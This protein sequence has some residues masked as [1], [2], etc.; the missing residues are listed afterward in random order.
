MEVAEPIRDALRDYRTDFPASGPAGQLGKPA[1]HPLHRQ[2][3]LSH[4]LVISAFDSEPTFD[5]S[6]NKLLM[7]SLSV[8]LHNSGSTLAAFAP[9]GVPRRGLYTGIM[10]VKPT[11]GNYGDLEIAFRSHVDV[12]AIKVSNTGDMLAIAEARLELDEE[13]DSVLAA[14]RKSTRISACYSYRL[15]VG[16]APSPEG[17]PSRSLPPL[18]IGNVA[19]TTLRHV[20]LD[21][22]HPSISPDLDP[23]EPDPS[24]APLWLISR[25]WRPGPP[26]LTEL[27]DHLNAEWTSWKRRQD[28]GR[29]TGLIGALMDDSPGGPAIV[30]TADIHSTAVALFSWSAY[31]ARGSRWSPHAESKPNSNKPSSSLDAL[32]PRLASGATVPP[33]SFLWHLAH[34]LLDCA[35][36]STSL[37]YRHTSVSSFLKAVWAEVLVALEQ[38]LEQGAA[39]PGVNWSG[40]SDSDP[41]PSIDLRRALLHQK[42]SMLNCCIRERNKRVGQLDARRASTVLVPAPDPSSPTPGGWRRERS[43]S[44]ESGSEPEEK[45]TVWRSGLGLRERGKKLLGF[46]RREETGSGAWG[47]LLSTVEK[48]TKKEKGEANDGWSGDEAEGDVFY[49]A[50]AEGQDMPASPEFSGSEDVAQQADYGT[51]F[52]SDSFIEVDRSAPKRSSLIVDEDAEHVEGELLDDDERSGASELWRDAGGN[53]IKLLAGGS[54]YIPEVQEHGHMTED[55]VQSLE[56]RLQ[57]LGHGHEAA[58]AR[59]EMQTAQLRSDMEAF[60]AANPHAVLEDFVRWHSPRDCTEI[61]DD[62]GDVVGIQLSSRMLEPGNLWQSLWR[63]A[64]RIPAVSQTPLFDFEGE[65]KKVMS[66]LWN[67][68][69]FDI[70]NQ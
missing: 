14:A 67:L 68:T 2:T 6:T 46:E 11:G 35:S 7:S 20:Q 4:F 37:T 41:G 40:S 48:N 65:A 15:S 5:L 38:C 61:T 49:E 54:F 62:S 19:G 33:D 55:M 9:I 26:Q 1:P 29:R 28:S 57:N 22:Y 69:P 25:E 21:A 64:R 47:D 16:H 10:L 36:P 13:D 70:L 56:E 44:D 43:T 32:L 3:G 60:K 63:K 39:V 53:P 30:E 24:A 23:E 17:V 45:P 18:H 50:D 66:D 34:R 42:L 58:K 52:R 31:E 27:L 8:A 59:A 12:R 51:S